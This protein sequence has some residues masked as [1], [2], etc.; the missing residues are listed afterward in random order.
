MVS[1][2]YNKAFT[3][4]PHFVQI[5]FGNFF[6]SQCIKE[7]LIKMSKPQTYQTEAIITKKIKKECQREAKPL[8]Y[9]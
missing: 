2:A 3:A 7:K 1:T 9:N 6:Y 8:L 5:A 4:S